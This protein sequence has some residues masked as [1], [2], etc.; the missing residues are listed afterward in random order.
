M[1]SYPFG[2]IPSSSVDRSASDQQAV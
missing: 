1:K 2:D